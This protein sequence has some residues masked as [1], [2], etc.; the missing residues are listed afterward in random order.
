MVKQRIL[1]AYG[2]EKFSRRLKNHLE[3]KDYSVTRHS[4][5]NLPRTSFDLI[6]QLG[7]KPADLTEGTRLLLEKAA[8]DKAKF[9]FVTFRISKKLY[10]EAVQFARSLAEEFGQKSGVRGITLN[11]GRIYGPGISEKDSGTLGHLIREFVKGETLT[12]Y[13]EGKDSDYY[14][15]LD[16]A[17]AGI[18]GALKKAKAGETYALSPTVPTASEAIAK[19]LFEL[20]GGRHEL[21]FH[22]GLTAL[23]DQGR[24]EGKPLPQFKAQTS[25]RQG[26]LATL[27]SLPARERTKTA[28]LPQLR[29]PLLKITLKKPSRR[30]LIIAAFIF[31]LL[32]FPLYLGGEAGLA[33]YRLDQA[34]RAL[35]R[36]DFETAGRSAAAATE[37]FTRLAKI[38]PAARVGVELSSTLTEFSLQG[39]VLNNA[40]ENL[41]RS[42]RG[43]ETQ[44][45]S[46]EEFQA[47]GRAFDSV[48]EHLSRAWLEIQKLD[49]PWKGYSA[50]LEEGVE[51]GLSVVQLGGVFASQAWDLLG[52]QGERNYLILFQNSTEL[53]AGG[54]FLGSLA[55]LTLKDGG[56]KSLQF[57]DS[58]QFDHQNRISAHPAFK[59]FRGTTNLPL[60]EA[61]LWASFPRSGKDIAAIFEEAQGIKIDGVIGT[62]LPFARDLIGV[63][64]E[65]DLPEFEKKVSAEN[66]FA[67]T[68][69]EVEKDFFPGSTKK[70][71]FLQALGEGLLEKLFSLE[72]ERYLPLGRV[73]WEGL[74]E[75]NLPLFIKQ[76]ELA[77]ALLGNNFDGHIVG[78]TDDYL[79]VL[80]SNFGTKANG[81]WIER[82]LSYRVLN[83]QPTGAL[84]G[85]L[86]L[87]WVHT[88]S[89]AW[90]SGTYKN[91]LRVLVPKGATLL[92]A[93]LNDKEYRSQIFVLEE[94]GKTEFSAYLHIKPQTTVTLK[95]NYRLPD[96][97]NVE[98]LNTYRIDIQKQP[99]TAG[100]PF[101]FVL[102]K[103]FGKKTESEEL[104]ETADRLT[105]EGELREDLHFEVTIEELGT[106]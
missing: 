47:L 50:S 6:I 94:A 19:L 40:L 89:T 41:R 28:K 81:V 73:I 13:G 1:L 37:N 22:R 45:Q 91:L 20:G 97:L 27:K 103:P 62:T 100:D 52:Y 90:P 12:L 78:G 29:K 56:I 74:K 67:I 82:S 15:F 87:T 68:T 63:T 38:F 95:L 99:G 35:S 44:P 39:D 25:F 8:K 77:Q 60:R 46:K 10:R 71:R 75:K 79:L 17:L 32:V 9:F 58:Y 80:D 76:G 69:E 83:P 64:G 101:T 2:E 84:Q 106:P 59:H 53:R 98:K 65:L 66:L 102:E 88:G 42:Y 92:S 31:L 61:N 24:V 105:F 51:E 96:H 86:V 34:K 43:E 72:E 49:P 36:L 48:E 104:Q 5:G 11:L 21:R 7:R 85:N 4:S 33:F 16:D 3:Q 55:Q 23:K 93:R 54:G 18:T 30:S 57:F 70:K 14:L 26:V